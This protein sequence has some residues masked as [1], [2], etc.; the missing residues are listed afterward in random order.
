MSTRIDYEARTRAGKAVHTFASPDRAVA[1][2]YAHADQ[3]DGLHAVAVTT[4]VM[5][6][7]LLIP[8]RQAARQPNIGDL[9]HG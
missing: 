5:T 8:S 6:R 7:R 4:V 9:H 2:V 3:Y 1:W